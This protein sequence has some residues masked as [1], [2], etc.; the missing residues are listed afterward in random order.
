MM[1]DLGMDRLVEAPAIFLTLVPAIT[2]PQRLVLAEFESGTPPRGDR[3][4]QER[5]LP[6]Q[7]KL[8]ASET[9]IRPPRRTGTT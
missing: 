9:G 8:V 6:H 1:T 4:A 2:S 5:T 7:R 3:Y